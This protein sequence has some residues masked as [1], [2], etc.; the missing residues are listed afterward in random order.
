MIGGNIKC[1]HS[2][3]SKYLIKLS[4]TV[5]WSQTIHPP[6]AWFFWWLLLSVVI[7][8]VKC[9]RINGQLAMHYDHE[10]HRITKERALCM[11]L[12]PVILSE[13]LCPKYSYLRN[14][15]PIVL[16]ILKKVIGKHR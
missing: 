7:A 2:Q 10:L 11:C 1:S 14:Q 12:L 6:R 9:G 16:I 4:L 3:M 5:L 8:R 13:N 15:F